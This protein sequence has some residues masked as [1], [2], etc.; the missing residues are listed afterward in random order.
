MMSP[1]LYWAEKGTPAD[2]L[3]SIGFIGTGKQAFGLKGSFQ[4]TN[5]VKIIAAADVYGSKLQQFAT[6][7]NQYYAAV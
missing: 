7:V 5:E 6:E 1:G 2:E 3:I 4:D